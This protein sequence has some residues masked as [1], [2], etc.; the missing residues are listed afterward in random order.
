MT[1]LTRPR[2]ARRAR[3][4]LTVLIL[5]TAAT[6]SAQAIHSHSRVSITSRDAVADERVRKRET[7]GWAA[8]KSAKDQGYEEAR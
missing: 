7:E 8:F 5:G 3:L 4:T 2:T 1:Q 6:A